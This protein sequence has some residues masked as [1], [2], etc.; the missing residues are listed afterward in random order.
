MTNVKSVII[1]GAGVAG[2]ATGCYAQMNGF[3]S[4]IFEMHF[5]P[6]GCCTAWKRGEYLFDWCI[7]WMLG[8]GH[9][10]EMSQIWTELG[11][12]QGKKVRNF[13]VFNFVKGEDG[14]TV[15]FYADP[16]RIE[17]H[18]KKISPQD[19][20]LVEEFCND[21]RRFK[22]LV[23]TYPFLKP[24]PLM[25]TLEKV[26]MFIKYLPHLSLFKRA[27]ETKMDDFSKRFKDP[28]LRKAFNYILF[29]KHE[30]FPLMPFYFNLACAA[31]ENAGVP[32]GGSIGVAKT[33]ES[34]YLSLG[35]SIQ[36]KASIEKIIV[37]DNQ[38]VGVRLRNG[39]E[40]YADII[41]STCDGRSVVFDMLGGKYTN[42]TVNKLYKELIDQ[43]GMIRKGAIAVFLGVNMDLSKEPHYTSYLLSDKEAESFS[44]NAYGCFHVQIRSNCS[45]GFCS[46]GKSVIL[47]TYIT[48]FD[49]WNNLYAEKQKYN[50][51]KNKVLEVAKIHLE[52]HY[53]GI[54]AS[55]EQTDVST[56][57]SL[58][59]YTGNHKGAILAW[60]PFNEASDIVEGFGKKYGMKLPGLNNFYMAGQ[61]TISGGLIRAVSSGRHVIQYVCKDNKIKFKA[62]IQG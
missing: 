2:L 49:Y 20:E 39:S 51:Q 34:R 9:G 32:E 57:V 54:I 8:S 29:D 17:E 31:M 28:L 56:P 38:A 40:H 50:Q 59:R 23:N 11:A 15:K 62:N 6:G 12:I 47:L 21:L 48:D 45:P 37:R 44:S 60:D 22:T 13:E 4:K 5:N 30:G 27:M 33:M 43:P 18:L 24:L 14:R 7:S 61:W 55:I 35:G 19:K 53:P 25:N 10:N 46:K 36:Y 26:K 52:R 1:I 16:D 58:K 41:I 3:K 42:E